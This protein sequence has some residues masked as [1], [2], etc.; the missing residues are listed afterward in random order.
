VRPSGTPD[1]H[2]TDFIGSQ[3]RAARVE[4]VAAASYRGPILIRGRRT[5]GAGAVGFGEGRV[6]DDELQLLQ[7]GQQA[8]HPLGGG[9]AWLSF[10]R[11]RTAGC[12]V[13]QVDGT[14]FSRVIAFRAR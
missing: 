10:T 6:P 3:W 7:S 2:V 13:Y 5:D 1:V 11:V 8:P 4:W 12:Y 14:N 9:R